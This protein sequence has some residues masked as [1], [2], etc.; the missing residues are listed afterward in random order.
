MEVQFF[1]ANCLR[2]NTKRAQIVVDDNLS[3][4]GEKSVSKKGDIALFTFPNAPYPKDA[5]LIIDNPG[6]YEV[7][8]VS[9]QGVAVRSHTDE[10][11]QQ[12]ATMFKIM[13]DELSIGITGHIHPDLTDQQLEALGMVDVLF[14]PVG[15]NGYTLDSVGALKVIKEVEPKI[16]VPTHYDQKGLAFPVPQQSLEQAIKGLS[17]EPKETLDKLKL[18]S[19]SLPEAT[20]LVVLSSA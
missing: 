17:M 3:N 10:K 19:G 8:G 18:K 12:T 11:D 2:I 20:Q 6:E 5:Q 7:S 16:V 9:L 1:G 14:V 13:T 4:L 15:G